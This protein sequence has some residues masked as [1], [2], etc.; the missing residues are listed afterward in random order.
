[1]WKKI[2][3]K[4]YNGAQGLS[5]KIQTWFG[6]PVSHKEDLEDLLLEADFGMDASTALANYVIQQRP[7]NW[8]NAVHLLKE[9]LSGLL[10]PYEAHLDAERS[11]ASNPW[12]VVFLGVNGAGKTTILGK[13]AHRWRHKRVRCIAADTFRAG[14]QRQLE[15]WAQRA[16]AE[17]TKIETL[18]TES[19][20]FNTKAGRSKDPGSLVYQGLQDAQRNNNDVILIDTAGRLPHRSDLMDELKK[21]HRV[22]TKYYGSNSYTLKTLLVLDGT[23]GQHMT[24][25]VSSFEKILP[26]SGMIVNKM[27]GTARA[28]MLVSLTQTFKLPIYGMGVGEG[29]E[30]WVNFDANFFS[31]ELFSMEK[32]NFF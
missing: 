26:L 31:E 19:D 6:A 13:L 18:S 16:K 7:T 2:K 23:T 1:M 12:I 27:D 5:E 3:E 11:C 29:I 9:H 15:I 25:Q 20:F 8:T 17:I 14:A 10:K 24:T 28:G 21:I 22:I 4:L 32:S 30:D